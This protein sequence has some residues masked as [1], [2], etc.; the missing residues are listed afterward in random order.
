MA[1]FRT[2]LKLQETVGSVLC[3]N[4]SA[5]IVSC[6]SACVTSSLQQKHLSVKPQ[7]PVSWNLFHASDFL[8]VKPAFLTRLNLKEFKQNLQPNVTK[9]SLCHMLYMNRKKFQLGDI[10]FL[11][12]PFNEATCFPYFINVLK[13]KLAARLFWTLSICV[14]AMCLSETAPLS[15]R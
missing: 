13:A 7:F 5:T 15:E 6:D 2:V 12:P 3:F 1:E 14:H 4:S 11:N 8:R 10:K 9:E